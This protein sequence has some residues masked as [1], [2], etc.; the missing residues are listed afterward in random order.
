L[1][2]A[3]DVT[4]Q[5]EI[6]FLAYQRRLQKI[7]IEFQN[8]RT[9]NAD[10][11]I[12][13][14]G[15]E[16]H[17]AA[18]AAGRANQLVY[19]EFRRFLN[20][21]KGFLAEN[22]A[23]EIASF[24]SRRGIGKTFLRTLHSQP[25]G[26]AKIFN[27]P[28]DSSSFTFSKSSFGSD[29]IQSN[30]TDN[31]LGYHCYLGTYDISNCEKIPQESEGFAPRIWSFI[32]NEQLAK[33]VETTTGTRDLI[34]T[35]KKVGT[36]V[37]FG[38]T[39]EHEDSDPNLED[40]VAL[41][42]TETLPDLGPRT[43]SD[44]CK[45]IG[46]TLTSFSQ[47]E[48]YD[49][50]AFR[51]DAM[52]KVTNLI[53]LF[54]NKLTAPAT[55]I[56]RLLSDLK[57]SCQTHPYF[58]TSTHS[59]DIN[60]RFVKLDF[61]KLKA[62][63]ISSDD[64]EKMRLMPRMAIYPPA[65][66]NMV[67]L[68]ATYFSHRHS[69]SIVKYLLGKW[70]SKVKLIVDGTEHHCH[71]D[72]VMSNE[73][74]PIENGPI[75]WE[76]K[77]GVGKAVE[78]D[79]VSSGVTGIYATELNNKEFWATHN[80]TATAGSHRA[81][82]TAAFLLF[83]SAT[84]Q[85]MASNDTQ[86]PF[87][88][89]AFESKVPDAFSGEDLEIIQE[90]SVAVS[91]LV[92][93]NG[94]SD[95]QVDYQTRIKDAIIDDKFG[96][97]V[98]AGKEELLRAIAFDLQRLDVDIL[99][100]WLASD[101]RL[102]TAFEKLK[103]KDAK[104]EKA[105]TKKNPKIEPLSEWEHAF[106]EMST[107]IAKS[108]VENVETG[109]R[110]YS[111][112]LFHKALEGVAEYVRLKPYGDFLSTPVQ[113]K[114][115]W[116]LDL[117]SNDP[118]NF[119]IL[120]YEFDQSE[121]K[122][123]LRVIAEFLESIPSS[124]EWSA[125]LSAIPRS[126]L[127]REVKDPKLSKLPT[128]F[129]A[130]A[131][132]VL[133]DQQ[134]IRQI[135]K[136]SDKESILRERINYQTFVRYH[137]P[138]AARMPQEGF[139]F[140]NTGFNP[141]Q[142]RAALRDNKEIEDSSGFGVLVSDLVAGQREDRSSSTDGNSVP[143]SLKKKLY[144]LYIDK[145]DQQGTKTNEFLQ[146]VSNHFR[147][148][149][150]KWEKPSERSFKQQFEDWKTDQVEGQFDKVILDSSRLAQFGDKQTEHFTPDAAT[151]DLTSA[152]MKAIRKFLRH[153]DDA[154]DATSR[155]FDPFLQ[156]YGGEFMQW[157]GLS[158]THGKRPFRQTN[159]LADLLATAFDGIAKPHSGMDQ[160]QVKHLTSVIHGDSHG[161]NLTW[162]DEF[163]QFQM[164]DFEHVRFGFIFSDQIKLV[165]STISEFLPSFTGR[166][167][168][169]DET[170]ALAKDLEEA[171]VALTCFS[172]T[173]QTS[174]HDQEQSENCH[175][176]ATELHQK[177]FWRTFRLLDADMIKERTSTVNKIDNSRGADLE[178]T[179]YGV[180][181]DVSSEEARKDTKRK[182]REKFL[183]SHSSSGTLTRLMRRIFGSCFNQPKIGYNETHN[184]QTIN[185]S[186]YESLSDLA[187]GTE[188]SEF[189]DAFLR[190][191]KAFALKEFTYLLRDLGPNE[192]RRLNVWNGI[193]DACKKRG[194][195]WEILNKKT[196]F[197][198]SLSEEE[199]A[200]LIMFSDIR[201]A[202]EKSYI[203]KKTGEN[204]PPYET[205]LTIAEAKKRFLDP[206]IS[207]F[208]RRMIETFRDGSPIHAKERAADE[209]LMALATSYFVMLA[210]FSYD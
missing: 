191:L 200:K 147:W 72:F 2:Q 108:N 44:L 115:T 20:S 159:S 193:N 109:N 24:R 176:F 155:K 146:A 30:Y 37:V 116:P 134:E 113:R 32:N 28:K 34:D 86:L 201:G 69:K 52:T 8:G 179:E 171:F 208:L 185:L 100:K 17:L 167:L 59:Q 149:S 129:S 124:E 33:E 106:R 79:D 152:N 53:P 121:L 11:P 23:I 169:I 207:V 91:H 110:Y 71:P 190:S 54:S 112:A 50:Q 181:I 25:E 126:L 174:D 172:E 103:K 135:L 73:E 80:F 166:K 42:S 118:S 128:G 21:Q 170:K 125:R 13:L 195:F 62:N 204:L 188:L 107:V 70:T 161:Q 26:V 198:S 68:D 55:N 64:Q 45:I 40:L 67:D 51:R 209:K 197:K 7:L 47:I 41:Y 94:W 199:I 58:G 194:D 81:V 74:R 145:T 196:A 104:N 46:L 93:L 162:S 63:I 38:R 60:I 153:C 111:E 114:R 138:L 139:A 14:V 48:R 66:A 202:K 203:E 5:Q 132:Y 173:L 168:A 206:R 183:T 3:D 36:C 102:R 96:K 61:V 83:K 180:A 178:S 140:D 75:F 85:A 189:T 77:D 119:D 131:I 127:T 99:K 97:R 10:D 163:R 49:K 205:K 122:E 82:T 158:L 164:I 130:E 105:A 117:L 192:L 27:E 9:Q 95:V 186:S 65:Y 84:S 43:A 18:S 87:G 6:D 142:E 148:K 89:L 184:L 150:I 88:I 19:E 12:S 210:V 4:G 165:V 177:F 133:D 101:G 98:A 39:S 15:K 157:P 92:D 143:N 182:L 175:P 90:I 76:D 160:L 31:E 35:I 120:S 151:K 78:E 57:M 56:S 22:F 187:R 154:F 29:S 144:Q 123:G 16:A 141:V 137:I 1:A 156:F 136:F